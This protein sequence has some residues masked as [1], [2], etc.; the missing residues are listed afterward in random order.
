MRTA[1]R[2][3]P[4]IT[5]EVQAKLFANI[6][7]RPDGIW[8]WKGAKVGKKRNSARVLIG[9]EPFY[10]NRVMFV[11]GQRR[12]NPNYQIPDGMMVC[13]K[14]DVTPELYDCN[15]DN[16]WLGTAL[17]NAL[18]RERKGR[19]NH[20]AKLGDL[21]YVRRNPECLKR[22][23]DHPFRTNPE[24]VAKGERHG[25]AKLTWAQVHEIRALYATAKFRQKE[26]AARFGVTWHN[27]KLIVNWKNWRSDAGN[28][29][30]VGAGPSDESGAPSETV[31]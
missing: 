10:V 22:G 4:Q 21:N 16:L 19:G 7:K 12:T 15:P 9:Y 30:A 20:E 18:D 1:P 24:L 28:A 8:A 3:I 17:D 25:N 5:P 13:H 31:A 2:P 6:E 14:H 27:I 26:L 29:Y 23:D 11:W